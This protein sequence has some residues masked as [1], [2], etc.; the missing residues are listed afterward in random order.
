MAVDTV[1][2]AAAVVVEAD[3]HTAVAVA[4]REVA[5][6]AAGME[7]AA[8]AADRKVAVAAQYSD[9]TFLKSCRDRS[10]VEEAEEIVVQVEGVGEAIHMIGFGTYWAVE[11]RKR[12]S[13]LS[14]MEHWVQEE[15]S[16]VD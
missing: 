4:D 14:R 16:T 12:H 5:V 13:L 11:E 8:A 6:A 2:N 7:V 1:P 9:R 15:S 3:H 10:V